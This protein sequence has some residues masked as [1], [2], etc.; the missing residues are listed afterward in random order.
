MS[1]SLKKKISCY[2]QVLGWPLLV[3]I[4]NSFELLLLAPSG[5]LAQLVGRSEQIGPK[6]SLS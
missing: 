5:W 4:H 1:L 3:H 2:E 6:S